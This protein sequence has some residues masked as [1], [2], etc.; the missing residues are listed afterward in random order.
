MMLRLFFAQEEHIALL[1]PYSMG[2][3]LA[4]VISKRRR[5]TESGDELHNRTRQGRMRLISG[6]NTYYDKSRN[7]N[8]CGPPPPISSHSSLVI[9]MKSLHIHVWTHKPTRINYIQL[10]LVVTIHPPL[11]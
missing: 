9:Y 7:G 2:K 8:P 11:V 6:P 4:I 3:S 10:T 1:E 5:E